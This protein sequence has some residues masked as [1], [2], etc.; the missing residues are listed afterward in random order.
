MNVPPPAGIQNGADAAGAG[1]VE[2]VLPGI[3]I[4]DPST[5]KAV[6]ILMSLI[7]LVGFFLAIQLTELLS[8]QSLPPLAW[9]YAV[10]HLSALVGSGYVG[11]RRSSR[12]FLLIFGVLAGII[13]LLLSFFLVTWIMRGRATV[14]GVV[15][16][17]MEVLAFSTMVYYAKVLHAKAGHGSLLSSRRSRSEEYQLLGL[18]MMDIAVFRATLVL[19]T[20]LAIVF[21]VFGTLA[22]LMFNAA[23]LGDH[24]PM[25]VRITYLGF[26]SMWLTLTLS[27]YFGVKLSSSGLLGLHVCLA[28]S[29]C[30]LFTFEVSLLLLLCGFPCSQAAVIAGAFAFV[31]ASSSY[32]AAVLR[33]KVYKGVNLTQLTSPQDGLDSNVVGRTVVDV[34]LSPEESPEPIRAAEEGQVK[35]HPAL[36]A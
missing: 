8:A 21:A 22:V 26:V 16:Q 18:P 12:T 10:S 2:E 14:E 36:S 35:P 15:I 31:F 30:G 23:L 28:A 29:L 5:L 6:Q 3:A 34:N 20:S 7:G 27:A 33:G 9:I 11:V 19:F 17:T 4:G 25:A 32:S 13:G 24:T 1:E